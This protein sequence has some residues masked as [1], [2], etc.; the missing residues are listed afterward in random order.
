M[1]Y[2]RFRRKEQ[3]MYKVEPNKQIKPELYLG[4]K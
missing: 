3:K 2:V 4:E 1:Y